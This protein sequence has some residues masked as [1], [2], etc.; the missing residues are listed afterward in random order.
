[1]GR[2]RREIRFGREGG[3]ARRV[4]REARLKKSL[5]GAVGP[6]CV[7]LYH[8]SIKLLELFKCL[9]YWSICY[10]MERRIPGTAFQRSGGE[11]ICGKRDNF[12]VFKIY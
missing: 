3:T 5:F 10:F 7:Y 8:I 12:F 1:M 6:V 4:R 2:G 11:A 9:N